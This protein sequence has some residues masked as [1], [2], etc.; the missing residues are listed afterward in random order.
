MPYLL[1]EYG[2]KGVFDAFNFDLE[3]PADF[4]GKNVHTYI[5]TPKTGT[6]IDYR[7]IP[8]DYLELSGVHLSQ[9]EYSFSASEQYTNYLLSKV[10]ERIKYE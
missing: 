6:L 3:L 5:D 9:S 2:K 8:G 4:T 1:K 10:Y 7:G